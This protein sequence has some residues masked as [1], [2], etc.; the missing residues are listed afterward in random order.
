MKSNVQI[1]QKMFIGLLSASTTGCFD[2]SLD[3]NSKGHMKCVSLNNQPY[4]ARLTF[5]DINFN[6]PLFLS[7]YCKC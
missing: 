3:S 5:V 2:G 7:I 4:K 6:E 1:Y